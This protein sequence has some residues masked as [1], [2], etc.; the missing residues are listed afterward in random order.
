MADEMENKNGE[1]K[2][3]VSGESK[4]TSEAY[5]K[6]WDDYDNRAPE[7]CIPSKKF[8]ITTLA[9]F[10]SITAVLVALSIIFSWEWTF[11][12]W[13]IGIVLCIVILIIQIAPIVFILTEA[14]AMFLMLAQQFFNVFRI[15]WFVCNVA[16]LLIFKEN[17]QIIFC[18][19]TVSGLLFGVPLAINNFSL[20]YKA[21]GVVQVLIM[22][23]E[24]ALFVCSFIFI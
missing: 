4:D 23:V 12:Q 16:L 24:V 15:V 22:L 6:T 2:H 19:L 10:L 17:Y 3:V 8:V 13:Y 9:V 14:G 5:V 1:S 21:L 11:W 18:C 20:T 7:P